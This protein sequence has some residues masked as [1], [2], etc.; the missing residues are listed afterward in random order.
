MEERLVRLSTCAPVFVFVRGHPNTTTDES[1]KQLLSLL[2][3]HGIMFSAMDVSNSPDLEA[4][5]PSFCGSSVSIPIMFVSGKFFGDLSSVVALGSDVRSVVP[6]EARGM[7][8]DDWCSRLCS[9]SPVVA[10]IKGTVE[11]PRCGFTNQLVTLLQS[12]GVLFSTHDVLSVEGLRDAMKRFSQWP[13]YP[14]LYVKGKF[15]GG[16]DVVKQ[17][18]ADDDLI[19]MI[20]KEA[21]VKFTTSN[22][23]SPCQ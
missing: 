11:R 15:V 10:F 4:A 9:S 21:L 3:Q 18:D 22:S 14:Q 1:S 2:R 6:E 17:L 12:R 19:Q 8:E 20:P 23:D 16:L 13:T 5:L 7:T